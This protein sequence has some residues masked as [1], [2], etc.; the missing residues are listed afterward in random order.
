[1]AAAAFEEIQVNNCRDGVLLEDDG[2][3]RA[4]INSENCMDPSITLDIRTVTDPRPDGAEVLRLAVQEIG[5]LP[6]PLIHVI[7]ISC[8][9]VPHI[10]GDA[11]SGDNQDVLRNPRDQRFCFVVHFR[12][13]CSDDSR[14]EQARRLRSGED[15]RNRV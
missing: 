5:E 15:S 1:M 4:E 10:I 3:D 11:L 2:A 9:I 12:N 8:S 7:A 6:S 14:T 13:E